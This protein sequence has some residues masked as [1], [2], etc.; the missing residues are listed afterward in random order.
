M[1]IVSTSAD[2]VKVKLSG[3]ELGLGSL[4]GKIV[5]FPKDEGHWTTFLEKFANGAGG[6][7][8]KLPPATNGT[9]LQDCMKTIQKT[10]MF[11]DYWGT[12]LDQSIVFKDN[13]ILFNLGEEKGKKVEY[14]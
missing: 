1:E 2:S 12:F 7:I 6:D 9:T 11:G 5:D 13:E 4:E 14:F 10:N 8:Y 3:G